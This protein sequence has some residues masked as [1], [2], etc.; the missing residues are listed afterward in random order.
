MS[1]DSEG[2]Y[3]GRRGSNVDE[4]GRGEVIREARNKGAGQNQYLPMEIRVRDIGGEEEERE[5]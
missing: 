2:L 3:V 4:Q 5:T 1:I